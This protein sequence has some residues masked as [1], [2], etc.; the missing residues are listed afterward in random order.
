MLGN[1]EE[2]TCVVGDY[3]AAGVTGTG[4]AQD[5]YVN[6]LCNLNP[7]YTGDG[8]SV[9]PWVMGGG[10]FSSDDGKWQDCRPEPSAGWVEWYGPAPRAGY[11]FV[12]PA[13]ADGQWA[14]HPGQQ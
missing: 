1:L 10:S 7:A 3:S 6:P 2:R 5:P 11:R 8:T 4:S 9:K 13:R 12:M 14:D